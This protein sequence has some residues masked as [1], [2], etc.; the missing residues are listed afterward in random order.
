M[1][2]VTLEVNNLLENVHEILSLVKSRIK[3]I[4]HGSFSWWQRQMNYKGFI[5]KH[6]SRGTYMEV[7]GFHVQQVNDSL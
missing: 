3:F 2:D 4:P 1:A 6:I 7:D 5:Y